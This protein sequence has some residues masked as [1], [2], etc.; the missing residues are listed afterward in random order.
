MVNYINASFLAKNR[1][2]QVI[3]K[4]MERNGDY[5]N[6]L[7]IRAVSNKD[8]ISVAGTIFRGVDAY[9]VSIDGYHRRSAGR[10]HALRSPY[11]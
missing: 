11:R 10:P 8:E 6:L 3:Q 4:Q 5:A 9:I 1:G 7:T 2:I